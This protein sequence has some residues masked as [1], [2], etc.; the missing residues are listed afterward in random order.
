M[1]KCQIVFRTINTVIDGTI[2]DER[3]FLLDENH[4]KVEFSADHDFIELL[5]LI[6]NKDPLTIRV[7]KK[8]GFAD[9]RSGLIISEPQWDYVHDFHDNFAAVC[10]GCE[11]VSDFENAFVYPS[12]GK[13]G[14]INSD[15]EITIPLQY[16]E[17]WYTGS[18]ARYR[19]VVRDDVHFAC[20]SIKGD[21]I[22]PTIYD[23][24]WSI[25]GVMVVKK[26]GLF[27][28]VDNYNEELL[29]LAYEQV[30]PIGDDA[31]LCKKPNQVWQFLS[32]GKK[33][34]YDVNEIWCY[35][36]RFVSGKKITYM[37]IEKA[38]NYALACDDGRMLSDFTLTLCGAKRLS[39]N[40]LH[41]YVIFKPWL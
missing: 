28:V 38:G 20:L 40:L 41:R 22:L 12:G 14:C 13:W 17:L 35:E 11:P 9:C 4:I 1:T 33:V 2:S 37:I 16:D 29:P 15:G 6:E 30:I 26:D 5:Q 34:F 39:E 19:A 10:L 18:S 23:G 8:W 25:P 3:I 7:A 21:M 32:H 27:G 36:N 31:Y 24:M